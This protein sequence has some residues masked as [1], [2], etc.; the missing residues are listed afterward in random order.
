MHFLRYWKKIFR[1]KNKHPKI[2]SLK[3]DNPISFKCN[4]MH[5]IL[6]YEVSQSLSQSRDSSRESSISIKE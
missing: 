4:V 1:K 3:Y 2:G 6:E 5:K